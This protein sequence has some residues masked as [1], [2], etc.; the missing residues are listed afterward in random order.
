MRILQKIRT[1]RRQK[2]NWGTL[3]GCAHTRGIM[4]VADWDRG[5]YISKGFVSDESLE[6]HKHKERDGGKIKKRGGGRASQFK[7]LV[8]ERARSPHFIQ[9][10]PA[11]WTIKA[12]FTPLP[13]PALPSLHP[14]PPDVA[15][16]CRR[17]YTL[18]ARP[19]HPDTFSAHAD[20][21]AYTGARPDGG[22]VHVRAVGCVCV[23][24][25]Q[26]NYA[27]ILWDDMRPD[28]LLM[29]SAMTTLEQPKAQPPP[30][31]PRHHPPGA[32]R[33]VIVWRLVTVKPDFLSEWQLTDIF[34]HIRR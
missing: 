21:C 3:I 4:C 32:S 23:F 11:S 16:G 17:I 22:D 8:P 12:Q 15:T 28:M 33:G 14:P 20:R 27:A 7:C 1:K 6:I 10:Y 24:K 34:S 29:R 31:V 18:R 19:L 13:T 25:R 26:W 30:F 2:T 5:H 9:S